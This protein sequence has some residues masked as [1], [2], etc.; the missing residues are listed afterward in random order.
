MPLPAAA[1]KPTPLAARLKVLA[2]AAL[3]SSGG[4]A[5]KAVHLAGWQVACFRSVIAAFALFVLVREVRR[6]PNLRVLG[7]GLAYACTLILFVLSTKLT[8]AAAAIYLQS[9]AP[10][11][12]LLLSP[13]LLKE[14]IRARDIVYM[15]ALALGLGLFFVGVDPVSATAPNPPLGNLLALA[16]GLTWALTVMGLRD[17]GRQ[18]GQESGSWAPAAAFWGNVFAALACLPLALPV[19]ASRPMDWVILGYLGFFQIAIAYLFLLRG[20]EKVRAFEASLLLLL[21]P[22]L[23]PL[24]AWLVHGERPGVG[25]LAGGGVIILATLVK[26]WVDAREGREGRGAQPE[27]MPD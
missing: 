24:W 21:E 13:W 9:T 27:P 11:Y 15:V 6:W 12:V 2:A 20:L 7:V 16:S 23:N 4:A 14:S 10:L 22:V 1:L 17:L 26:S 3:F 18:A 25:S 8:T 19:L 5:I